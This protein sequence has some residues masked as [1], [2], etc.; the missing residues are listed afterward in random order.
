MRRLI[1][2]PACVTVAA[3]AW[4]LFGPAVLGGNATYVVTEGSS[5]LPNFAPG[6]L[7]IAKRQESYATGDVVAYH[8]GELGGTLVL[9]RIVRTDGR[10][11]IMQGDNN[12]YEDRYQPLEADLVGRAWVHL[13]QVGEYFRRAR[14]PMNFGV[15]LAVLTFLSLRIPVRSS[16]RRRH[17][18]A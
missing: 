18:P 16:R 11:F 5:M 13:P 3:C 4:L 12:R 7:V 9:H 1:S 10:R 6:G 14:Q 17:H 2:I 15:I 8:S